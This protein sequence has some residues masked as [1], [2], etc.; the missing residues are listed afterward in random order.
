MNFDRFICVVPDK[1]SP[2]RGGK[3]RRLA[4]RKSSPNGARRD[5]APMWVMLLALVVATVVNTPAS[6][7]NGV[8]P[9]AKTLTPSP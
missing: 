1:R 7:A 2:F 9:S 5:P 6:P 3:G 4:W 8:T